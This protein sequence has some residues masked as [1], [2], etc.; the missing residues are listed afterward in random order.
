MKPTI[1]AINTPEKKGRTLPG[2]IKNTASSAQRG[3]KRI[4]EYPLYAVNI[5]RPSASKITNKSHILTPP[6]RMF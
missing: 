6:E 2:L 5:K 3:A 1:F 4:T